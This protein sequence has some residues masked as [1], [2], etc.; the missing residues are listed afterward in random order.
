MYIPSYY[1]ENDFPTLLAFIQAHPFGVLCSSGNGGLLATHLPFVAMEKD[2]HIVIHGHM[3]KANPH[4]KDLEAGAEGLLIFQ[5][6]NGYVSP[7]NYERKENV[8]TWNY[9][10]VHAEGKAR[11]IQSREESLTLLEEMIARFEPDYAK[12]WHELPAGYVDGMLAGIVA[13]EIEVSRLEGKF[14]LSQNKTKAE[15]ENIIRSFSEAGTA[16]GT[17]LAEEMIKRDQEH[18]K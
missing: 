3:A 10:A 8:P 15:K 11:I 12:Q 4:W 16:N 9:I 1:K 5:G 6:P 17:K 13:F 18:P 14:K 2:Q 7:S